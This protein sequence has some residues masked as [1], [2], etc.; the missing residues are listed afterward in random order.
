MKELIWLKFFIQTAPL[1]PYETNCMELRISKA[2]LN[3]LMKCT[4]TSQSLN[5]LS[6]KLSFQNNKASTT[7][8]DKSW[9]ASLTFI[10][11]L[12]KKN[13][14]SFLNLLPK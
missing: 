10:F 11:F 5:S 13:M 4:V 2:P 1:K 12:K 3:I 14:C 6:F 9:V 7:E 8:L